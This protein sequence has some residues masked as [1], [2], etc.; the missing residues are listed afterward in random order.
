[1][2]VP[3]RGV[4]ATSVERL[5]EYGEKTGKGFWHAVCHGG[6]NVDLP[7]AARAGLAQFVD[8]FQ[9]LA[10]ALRTAKRGEMSV[11]AA[12]LF[13]ALQLRQTIV[14]A[15]ETAN[16][17]AKRLENLDHVTRALERFEE[18][19]TTEGPALQEFLRVSALTRNDSEVEDEDAKLNKVTMMT[20]HSAKGLEFLYVFLVGVEEELLPHKRTI[21]MALDF[22]EE[23]RLC[24]VG[25]TRARRK[26]WMSYARNRMRYGKY[27]PRTPS[28]F[29]SE[30]PN[31]P[32][33]I[34]RERSAAPAPEEDE[35]A[36]ANAFFAKMKAQLGIE[37]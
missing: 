18:Y 29:L 8:M 12:K 22:G 36:Q 19:S 11:H 24:Y 9:P 28:R 35:E 25:M 15:N 1:I 3:A 31:E 23:R 5:V 30:M 32:V 10:Q 21:E 7:S 20:L 33:V 17:T 27:E 6:P 16:V 26:L 14:D 2:N 37:G 13:E 4:G 34:R